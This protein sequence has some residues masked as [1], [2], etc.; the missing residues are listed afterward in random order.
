MFN[1]I[2]KNQN[3]QTAGQAGNTDKDMSERLRKLEESGKRRG[4]I[5][6]VVGITTSFLVALIAM[7]ASHYLLDDIISITGKLDESVASIPER[8][9]DLKIQKQEDDFQEADIETT[10]NSDL[11]SESSATDDWQT[12]RNDE[13]GIEFQHP[14]DWRFN[15][16]E[17]DFYQLIPENS[18][19]CGEVAGEWTCLDSINFGVVK[20]EKQLDIKTFLK[21]EYGWEPLEDF[22]GDFKEVVIDN[23][24]IFNF[25]S[26]NAFD[27]SISNSFWV[28]LE[29]G[30]FFKILDLYLVDQQVEVYNQIISTIKFLKDTDNDGLFDD[31][32]AEYGCDMNNPDT[33]GDGFLDGDEVKN[34]YNPAGEGKL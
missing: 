33:D 20:N 17:N 22:I 27:A 29:D 24:K 3:E 1:K 34:G 26:I 9:S 30:N 13:I 16:I 23:K 2:N 10:E 25:I 32:E 18:L 21:E 5:Y 8:R 11:L 28:P 7:Y 31:E 12:Y 14:I 19:N 15:I 6:L 4:K